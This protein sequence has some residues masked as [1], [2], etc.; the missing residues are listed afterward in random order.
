ML[1][2]LNTGVSESDVTAT[3]TDRNGTNAKAKAFKNVSVNPTLYTAGL[4][5][6]SD[7][8]N[9]VASTIFTE[10]RK[11]P[12]KDGTVQTK[13][14]G[15]TNKETTPSFKVKIYDS[16]FDD[17]TVNNVATNLRATY[18]S[19][20]D[21]PTD[22]VGIDIEGHDYFIILNHDIVDTSGGKGVDS[23]NAHFAKITRIVSF[24]EFGDGVEFSPKYGGEIPKGTKFEIYK[25]ASKTD[26]D[27]DDLVAVSYGL[28][29][30]TSAETNKYDKIC[31]VNTPTFYFYNDRLEEK[32]QLDYNEKYTVTST[33]VW[34]SESIGILST[35]GGNLTQYEQGSTTK[36]FTVSSTVFGKLTEGMSLF[37]GSTHIGNIEDVYANDPYGTISYRFYLDYA[38]VNL[39][40]FSSLTI[41]TTIQNVVFKTERKYDNTIQNKGRSLMDAILVDNVLVDDEDDSN[42]DPLYWNKAFPLMKRSSTDAHS[43][44]G[45]VWTESENLN[46]AMKYITFDTA[47]LKNDKIPTTLDTI[48]NNPKNKMSKMATVTT[49]DN[50]GTQH[51]KVTEDSKMIV[52][53]GLFSDSMKLKKIEHTVSKGTTVSTGLRIYI[54]NMNSE[55]DYRSILTTDSIVKI[56]DYYYTVNVINNA[57]SS[58]TNSQY[59]TSKAYKQEKSNVWVISPTIQNFTDAEL[60]VVHYS[61]NKLNV[62]FSSDTTVRHDQSDRLTLDNRTVEVKNTKLYNS[63]LSITNKKGHDLRVNYGDKTHKYLTVLEPTKHYYQKTPISRMYYYNGSFTLNEEIFNGNVEDIESKNENGMMTYTISGRDEVA[64]LLTNTVNKNLNFTD[65][66]VYSTL[67]PHIDNL[68]SSYVAREIVNKDDSLSIKINVSGEI[69]F[70]KYT[71]FFNSSYELL[72]EYSSMEVGGGIGD[73]YYT[74]TLKDKAYTTAAQGSNIYYYNP[75]DTSSR[76]ISGVKALATNVT[77]SVRPTDFTNTSEK[78]LIFNE[79]LNFTYDSSADSGSNNGFTYSDLKL[80]SNNGSFETDGSYGYDILKPSKIIKRVKMNG[81]TEEIED[82]TLLSS[83]YLLKIGKEKETNIEYTQKD[84]VS[85]EMFNVI[86]TNEINNSKN[87]VTIAPNFPVFL[88]IQEENKKDTRFDSNT[89]KQTGIYLLNNNLNMGGF[90]HRLKKQFQHYYAPEET[91]KFIDLNTFKNNTLIPFDL[92]VDDEIYRS[93][94]RP[95]KIKGYVSSVKMLPNGKRDYRTD[96]T[97]DKEWSKR[98]DGTTNIDSTV[99][100]QKQKNLENHDWRAR[101]YSLYGIGDLYPTSKLRFNNISFTDKGLDNYGLMFEGEGTKGTKISHY[102]LSLSET[103]KGKSS[104][105]IKDDNN[106]E[107]SEI[108]SS[109]KTTSQFKRWGIIRLVEATFDWHFNAVD[110]E[111]VKDLDN[112]E[113]ISMS[114]YRKYDTNNS[115]AVSDYELFTKEGYKLNKLS[116]VPSNAAKNFIMNRI[117]M[118]RPNLHTNYFNFARIDGQVNYDPPNII[119]PMISNVG[120]TK[121]GSGTTNNFYANSAFHVEKLEGATNAANQGLGTEDIPTLNSQKTHVSK[122]LSALCKPVI[123][124]DY[125]G[126]G[127]P[128]GVDNHESL[129]ENPF[130]IAWP[131][132]DIYENCLALFKDMKQG[133]TQGKQTTLS[134]SSSPLELNANN[135]HTHNTRTTRLGIDQQTVNVMNVIGYS[136]MGAF[137]AGAYA[138]LQEDENY[139]FIGAKTKTYPFA[140][141]EDSEL[142]TNRKTGHNTFDASDGGEMYSAQMF[143]KP[144]LNITADLNANTAKPFTMDSTSTHHWLNFVPN[145]TGYYIVGNKLIDGNFIPTHQ[146]SSSL[147]NQYDS[148]DNSTNTSL[149]LD[150]TSSFANTGS[151]KINGKKFIWSANNTTTN[152]LTVSATTDTNATLGVDYEIGTEVIGISDYSEKGTPTYIGKIIFHEVD[153]TGTYDIHS[154]K[155]DKSI[156]V[157]ADG[158]YFRLMRISDTVFEETPDY[159]EVNIMQDSGLQYNTIS[160]NLLTGE[161]SKKTQYNEGI[162][163]MYMLLNM[164]ETNVYLDRRDLANVSS[165][166]F[167]DGDEINCYITDGNNSQT[168][169]LTV[170]FDDGSDDAKNRALKFE[171]DGVLNGDGCVSF[172]ETFEVTI[173]KKLSIKPTKCYLGT[174]FSIGGIVENEIENIAKEAGLD[175]NYEQ[176]L[177]DYTT[178]LVDSVSGNVITCVDKPIDVVDGDVLYTQEGYLVGKVSAVSATTIT[179]DGIIFVPSPYDELIRRQRKTHVSNVRFED[180]DSFS[181]INFLANKRGLDYKISNG[182]IIAKNIED[183]HSLRR[184]S[185]SYKSGHNLISVESNKSLFDKANKIIVVGDGVKAESEIPTKGR[186]KTI[187][188]VDSAIKSLSDAKIKATQLLQIHNADIR[189]IKLKIQKEGLE[190]LEAGDILTLDFPNHDIPIND[191]QVFEIENILDGVSTITVGTFNKTIAERLGE[192]SSNQTRSSFTLFGKNSTQS[193]V[194]KS[195][196]DSFTIQNGTIEYKITASSETTNLGFNSPLG[197]ST[198]LG[199]GSGST[200]VLK[201]YKSEKDV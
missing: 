4:Q 47:A 38:R 13:I 30:D 167:T 179:V 152:T 145:L 120:L 89:S 96:I 62:E 169:S 82:E 52:R 11:E 126:D 74:V 15:T 130:N 200:T 42:F 101:T 175:L 18:H 23:I 67:N 132:K 33:R 110:A 71:L 39:S 157:S 119:L 54:E 154:L 105:T 43:F 128:T 3:Y 187:R 174:T 166:L 56:N 196:F 117:Y 103:I 188:H 83:T 66:I 135:L 185:I 24:D 45:N 10:I 156:D 118:L 34:G 95:H 178:N 161:V 6:E 133:T 104:S 138:D 5:E 63:R 49:L 193:V 88:G 164:D 136:Q 159:F 106:Y 26:N 20:S 31:N 134:L 76:F 46:G 61:N 97:N 199:F 198:L 36:Y 50:S 92:T 111:S 25:G 108:I 87:I 73:L 180:T 69:V 109:T 146:F 72:G 94:N 81:S 12:R 113:K 77:E 115:N 7:S 137:L 140:N 163:S 151:G 29:G 75:L 150:D 124:L 165:S 142:T 27:Y 191:Y 57:W 64:N 70:T 197:F 114:K 17:E 53:N 172:G 122:V 116:E 1:F 9:P 147:V 55:F 171:Y 16:N 93:A 176:S 98:A 186:T 127:S 65:D 100:I 35:F 40:A 182:E 158:T 201:T 107:L 131:N 183:V 173:P 59:F 189:K 8:T 123:P 177:R 32:N 141:R 58:I 41:G 21:F 90:I 99:N 68:T 149:V 91:F 162:Y 48:V 44:S 51:L 181:A 19:S 86:S 148:S 143:V 84:T 144:R 2:P 195:I 121:V 194:G 112:F 192:L 129:T 28:R 80:T 170:T 139:S 79:G 85:S 37:N 125:N 60:Y 160:E 190:L 22:R 168:K 155:F 153:E 78:G 14:V 102:D 184:F